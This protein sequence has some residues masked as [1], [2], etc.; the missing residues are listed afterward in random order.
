MKCFFISQKSLDVF[1]EDILMPLLQLVENVNDYN[2]KRVSTKKI[3]IKSN[4]K[5]YND[6]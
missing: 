1:I 6:S 3:S 4:L 2:W 5:N